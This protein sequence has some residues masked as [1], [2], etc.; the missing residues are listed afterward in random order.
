MAGRARAQGLSHEEIAYDQLDTGDKA[1]LLYLAMAN[2]AEGNL[3]IVGMLLAHK[4]VIPSLGD[5]GAHA[6]TTCDGSYST[7][8]LTHWSRDRTK[9]KMPMHCLV[10]QLTS[11]PAKLMGFNDRGAIA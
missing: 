8:L 3:Y 7:Y 6:A 9:T 5:C 2:F 4:G 10:Q 1:Q 11:A